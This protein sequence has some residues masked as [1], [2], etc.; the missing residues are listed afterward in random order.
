M[1]LEALMGES[2]IVL[3]ILFSYDSLFLLIAIFW[4]FVSS[5]FLLTWLWL[6]FLFVVFFKSVSYLSYVWVAIVWPHLTLNAEFDLLVE[7]PS[8]SLSVYLPPSSLRGWGIIPPRLGRI[9]PLHCSRPS[10]GQP[11]MLVIPPCISLASF[12]GRH[13]HF[14]YKPCSRRWRWC[15]ILTFSTLELLALEF[16]EI[17][18][19]R[20]SHPCRRP[21]PP[22]G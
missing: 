21:S 20:L 11:R 12:L 7:T 22:C 10:N 13:S 3:P 5:P 17:F 14:T 9:N 1:P 8:F 6:S 19:L 2:G 15:L 16:W 18:S 4:T